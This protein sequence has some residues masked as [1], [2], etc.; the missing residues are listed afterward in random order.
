MEQQ[1]QDLVDS[2]RKEGLEEAEKQ[3]NEIIQKAKAEADRIIKEA[4][5][6]AA[7][8]IDDAAKECALREQSVKASISQAAR[9]VSLSL[10]EEINRQ[11]AAILSGEI[12]S[13]FDKDLVKKVV[14]SVIEA[15]LKDIDIEISGED[16]ASMV[17]G[18]SGELASKLRGGKIRSRV[19]GI[20][21]MKM[22]CEL[23]DENGYRIFMYGAKEEI[24]QKAK[25]KLIETYPNIQIAGTMNGYQ[26]DKQAV[27]DAINESKADIVLVAMGSPRQ[28][29]WIVENMN[30]VCAKVF[31]G[32][33][34]SFDV[35]SG[36]IPRAPQWMQKC[37]L[38]WLFR[39]L[40]EPKR[41]GRQ[42]HLVSFLFLA[43]FSRH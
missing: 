7:K 2:I 24:L 17:K 12:R 32:V 33:G 21:S 41:I 29:N 19:T 15:S 18:L 30:T 31:Q 14:L 9:D 26:K 8:M 5:D 37:G 22:L 20:D 25:E 16:A 27:V 10:R 43:L 3:R 28:E 1:I 23:S 40:R 13:S 39:L 11:L 4:K 6:N 42:I 35:V 38:E 36:T 34:G